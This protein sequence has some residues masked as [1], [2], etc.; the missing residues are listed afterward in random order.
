MNST[1]TAAFWRHYAELPPEVKRQAKVAIALFFKD[2]YYPSL[3]FKR[4]CSYRPCIRVENK[5]RCS[6][7]AES[8]F[9]QRVDNGFVS[10]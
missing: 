1:T 6:Q 4:V 2:P 7:L 3:H 5:C 8:Q 10:V 9:S